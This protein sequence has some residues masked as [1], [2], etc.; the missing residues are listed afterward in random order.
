MR[1]DVEKIDERIKKLQMIRQLADDPEMVTILFE[2]VLSDESRTVPPGAMIEMN[3][4]L[5][6]YSV[7][8]GDVVNDVL[9]GPEQH[10]GG[11]LWARRRG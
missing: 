6:E 4:G 1:L 5:P 11:S 10:S 2:F 9:K 7:D 3:G 8:L